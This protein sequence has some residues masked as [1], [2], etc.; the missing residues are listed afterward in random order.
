M[1]RP[2]HRIALVLIEL[3]KWMVHIHSQAPS[4]GHEKGGSAS[5]GSD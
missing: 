2:G 4:S 5:R 1:I 3:A